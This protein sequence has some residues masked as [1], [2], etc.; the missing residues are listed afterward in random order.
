MAEEPQTSSV[1][2]RCLED[3]GYTPP[4]RAVDELLVAL[5]DRSEG[6][7]AILERALARTG[8][9]ALSRVL[10]A[11][12]R[13]AAPE[14]TRLLS[15]GLRFATESADPRLLGLFETALAEPLGQSRKLAA[16]GLAKLADPRA[17][18]ALLDRLPRAAG[19]ELKSVVDALGAL[20][21]QQ[22][23]EALKTI[24]SE[25]PDLTRRRDRARLMIER[26][27]TRGDVAALVFDRA[28]GRECAVALTCRAGLT[29][30]LR[31]ELA[32]WS[33]RVCGPDRIELRHSGR[34]DELLIARTALEI[35]L[36]IP[37]AAA[38]TEL[39]ER[40][41]DALTRAETLAALQAWTAG[42]PRFR[43]AWSDGAHHRALT[44]AL[45]R[46]VR[47]RTN[48][49]VNDSQ[50]ALW[51]LRAAPDGERNERDSIELVPR[52]DPD[53][54]FAYRVRDVPAASHPTLAAA[55]AHIAGVR[56]EDVVWDPFVGS[57]LELVECA[58]RGPVKQLWGTDIDPKALLAARANLDSAGVAGAQLVRASA[59]SFAPPGVSLI[60][61]NPP[62]GRRV[63]RDGSLGDLLERFV[64]HAATVLVPS[65]RLVW[66]SPLEQKTARVAKSSGLDVLAGPD[67][68]LGGFSARVQVL[69]RP[70]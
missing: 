37:L 69:T 32:P 53:P 38:P 8:A 23:L 45:A 10:S 12:Q 11:Y 46:A 6:E 26:R 15:L 58:K 7:A 54:R 34:L 4:L 3:S 24:A 40:I 48:V 20:G 22:S 28:L 36:V 18:P 70:A 33:P 43:I 68:D 42:I 2:Q 47:A 9:P 51:S 1:L 14:R 62:M 41:A 17:E 5:M 31:D 64:Q 67:V 16:R 61:S 50:A 39:A 57:G 19:A 49:L 29:E 63:A 35:G 30:T 27:Q 25:D 65:G 66:L 60:V 44:W 59:L 13:S 21:Q 55:L 52:L 56:S